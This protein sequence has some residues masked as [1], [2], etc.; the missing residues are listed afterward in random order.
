MSGRALLQIPGPT[1]VPRRVLQAIARP[2]IDHRG[3]EFAAIAINVHRD[4]RRLVGTEGPVILFPA[5]GTGAWEAALVNTMSPGDRVLVYETGHFAS[6]WARVAARLGLDPLVVGGDWRR[7]V[8]AGE[9]AK[10]LA[11]DREN[12]IRAVCIVHNET[13]TG[14]LSDVMLVRQAMDGAGHPALL[15]VDT[16]SS[17]GSVPY[18]HDALGVDVTVGA[19][20]KGLMLPPGLSFNAVSKDAL[21]AHRAATCPR[22]YWDW[23]AMLADADKGAYPFTPATNLVVGLAEALTM[24]LDEEGMDAVFAR[25]Q[26]L[27]EATRICVEGWGLEMQC[28]VVSDRS[29]VLTA[30]RLPN[31]FDA[32]ALRAIIRDRFD[33]ALGNGLGQIAGRVFR[34]G[35]LG[36]FNETMLAGTLAAVEIGLRLSQ[37]PLAG[38]GVSRAL[39]QLGTTP[40]P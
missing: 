39:E 31:G 19:S 4:L 3:P 10:A 14:A 20:Q 13:S 40:T 24:L 16:I 18:A 36:D 25:H 33:V 21:A 22:A 2:T 27:A 12:R 37:V 17:L 5:S 32:D 26:R 23:T 8:V 6:L 35:H 15:L 1:N 34:I 29:N 30:V 38:S 7:G 9:I 28:S 11:S